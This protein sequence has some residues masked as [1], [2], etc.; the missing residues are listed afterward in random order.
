M[1][2]LCAA[3]LSRPYPIHLI[4]STKPAYCCCCCAGLA[5]LLSALPAG[6]LEEL[7]LESCRS[8]NRAARQAAARGIA[9]LQQYLADS[10]FS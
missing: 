4:A 8:L 6:V 7:H 3:A 10:K 9:P 5:D 2:M 1:E